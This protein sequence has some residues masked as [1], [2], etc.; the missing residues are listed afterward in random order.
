MSSQPAHLTP[1]EY[2]EIERRAEFRSEYYDGEMFA[3][4]GGTSNHALI[5]ANICG[6]IRQRLKGKPCGACST[7]L[8]LQVLPTLLYTYPDVMVICGDMQFADGHKDM[9]LNPTVIVEVLSKSTADYDLG[10]KF[11]HYRTLLSLTDYL[12]VA[13]NRPAV[14]HRTRHQD[15]WLLKTYTDLAQVI[16]LTSIAV[17]LPLSEIYDKIDFTA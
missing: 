9:I 12:T 15:G 4:A 8:R 1:A 6:E 17:D 13:Q 5:V 14:D 2:L 10:R 11:E 16:P 3:M 7:D